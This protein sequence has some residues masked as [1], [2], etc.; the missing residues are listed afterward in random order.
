[1]LLSRSRSGDAELAR[2]LLTSAQS[3]AERLGMLSLAARVQ[4]QPIPERS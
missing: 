1:M 2:D 4:A 3:T